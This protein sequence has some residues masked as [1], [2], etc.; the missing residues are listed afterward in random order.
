M[1]PL[2]N[3]PFSISSL[4][5]PSA[6]GI[7]SDFANNSTSNNNNS[8]RQD[9]PN[10]LHILEQLAMYEV[11]QTAAN[12]NPERPLLR[13]HHA[14]IATLAGEEIDKGSRFYIPADWFN[15]CYQI[16]HWALPPLRTLSMMACRT[17]H[18]L[19]NHFSFVHLPTFRLIDTAAC[20]AFAI[21]TVGGIRTGNSSILDQY[22]WQPP[23]GNGR[24]NPELSKALDGPVVPD[25]SWESLYEENWYRHNEPVRARQVSDV[26]NWKNGPVVRSEKTNML[27]KSFSLARGVLMTEYNVALLQA[28]I[29]YHAP[30]FLSEDERER[31]SANMFLGTIVNVRPDLLKCVAME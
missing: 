4:F 24:P 23:T 25:Q 8:N 27:V 21:C 7:S 6:H 13:V 2:Q 26:A 3:T 28:L 11:P 30:N 10:V 12:P 1:R 17:F 15:G 16:P 31:A 29:L 18:T 20:L 5:S 22:L 19:L 14:E 9:S